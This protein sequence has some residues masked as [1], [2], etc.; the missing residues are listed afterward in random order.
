[1]IFSNTLGF[2][3]LDENLKMLL[4]GAFALAGKDG[5]FIGY[6]HDF[7]F[8]QFSSSSIANLLLTQLTFM[9]VGGVLSAGSGIRTIV[10]KAMKALSVLE[11]AEGEMITIVAQAKVWINHLGSPYGTSTMSSAFSTLGSAGMLGQVALRFIWHQVEHL[12]KGSMFL[13]TLGAIGTAFGDGGLFAE[14]AFQGL[15]VASVLI[16]LA[17]HRAMKRNP[18]GARLYEDAM[19]FVENEV[20]TERGFLGRRILQ[21]RESWSIV[22]QFGN[23]ELQQTTNMLIILN[24]A[25]MALQVGTVMASMYG[26]M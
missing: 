2:S 3:V 11:G 7:S 5:G 15:L 9:V 12:L 10:G 1:M 6:G 26:A 19:D 18:F 20:G 16:S 14:L 21:F 8:F 4:R 13:F 23:P 25:S 17:Q 24:I 22:R